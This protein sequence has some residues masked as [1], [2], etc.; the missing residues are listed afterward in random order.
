V[1]RERAALLGLESAASVLSRPLRAEAAV[2]KVNQQS[3]RIR[4][5]GEDGQLTFRSRDVWKAVPGH[6]VTLVIEKRWT[7]RDDA[8]ASGRLENIRIAEL[9]LPAGFDGV[10]VWG[11]IYN[12]FFLRCL[13]GYGL[14][15]WR[16]DKLAE[17][18]RVFESG[19]C[20]STRTTTK[21]CVS[22]G[23]T[24]AKTGVGVLLARA[25]LRSS[26]S[27]SGAC[28]NL[29]LRRGARRA[30][31]PRSDAT[32]DR[33]AVFVLSPLRSLA[34]STKLCPVGARH[35]TNRGPALS[36]RR[37]LRRTTHRAPRPLR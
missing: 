30:P 5:L 26:R 22:A 33:T 27:G 15:L 32:S 29:Q 36:L 14:C 3:A 9:S 35:S 25:L 10:L 4:L 18:Q 6:L 7:R 21:A 37:T 20:R 17:A 23:K 13:H 8:Y 28:T 11:R 12:R 34:R 19:S 2:L 1:L 31:I 24:S 16:L